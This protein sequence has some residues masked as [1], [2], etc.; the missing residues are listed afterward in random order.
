MEKDFFLFDYHPKVFSES[1]FNEEL[2]NQLKNLPLENHLIFYGPSLSGKYTKVMMYLRHHF[3]P[4][5]LFYDV[6][7]NDDKKI[8]LFKNQYIFYLDIA[9]FKDKDYIPFF[10][11]T[12]FSH[13]NVLS[14]NKFIFI[15]HHAHLMNQNVQRKLISTMEKYNVYMIFITN[16]LTLL[17]QSIR[18]RCFSI[19]CR[20]PNLQEKDNFAKKIIQ[21]YNLHFNQS[22][23]T[24][25]LKS[26]NDLSCITYY[27]FGKQ[28][29]STIE[30][31]FQY[32][33]LL[34]EPILK[35]MFSEDFLNQIEEIQKFNQEIL[36][37]YQLDFSSTIRFLYNRIL[38]IFIKNEFSND[39][40]NE[41]LDITTFYDVTS[42]KT[43]NLLSLLQNYLTEVHHIISKW[44]QN[45]NP[46]TPKTPKVTKKK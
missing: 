46:Q 43:T 39:L 26:I 42:I 37:Y 30:K 31:S 21:K 27:L 6:I 19:R 38:S 8:V 7:E 23:L 16:S 2:D 3:G 36:S 18:D 32:P 35:L 11:E 1:D 4:V 5:E 24:L 29:D 22:H 14:D 12:F 33:K 41:L 15:I 10:L 45:K 9:L 28:F 20:L 40:L 34:F 44:N 13:Q 17:M 25:F